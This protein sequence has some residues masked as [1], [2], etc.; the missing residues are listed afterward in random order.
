MM[1]ESSE[2]IILLSFLLT[3]LYYY[4]TR[5]NLKPIAANPNQGRETVAEWLARPELLR[6]RTG[7]QLHA[8]QDLCA[9]IRAKTT[10]DDTRYMSLEE[11]VAIFLHICHTGGG[12]D[13]TKLVFNRSKETISRYRTLVYY[14]RH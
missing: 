1:D 11:K 12:F 8:F 9:W 4:E 7:L 2:T 14:S 6:L 5:F 13:N 3:I 10:L